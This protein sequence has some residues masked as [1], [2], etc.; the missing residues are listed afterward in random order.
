MDE[1]SAPD[2]LIGR[3]VAGKFV[4]ERLLGAGA[5]G[6]VYRARQTALEPEEL[7]FASQLRRPLSNAEAKRRR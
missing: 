3:N 2:P 4:I 6:A 5:M 1:G 7:W